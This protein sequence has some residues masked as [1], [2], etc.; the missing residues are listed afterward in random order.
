MFQ[1]IR[2]FAAEPER[3]FLFRIALPL[4]AVLALASWPSH[5]GAQEAAG[6]QDE[7]VADPAGR[8]DNLIVRDYP[9]AKTLRIEPTRSKLVRT[10]RPV[11]RLSI[12]DPN[13]MDVTQYSPEEFEFIGRKSGETTLTIWFGEEG[14][15]PTVVRY[16]VQVGPRTAETPHTLDSQPCTRPRSCRSNR[17]PAT[18]FAVDSTAPAPRPC[19]PRKAISASMFHAAPASAEPRTNTTTPMHRIGLRP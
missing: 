19:S 12:T 2:P 11:T 8:Q 1:T 14:Q 4:L 16:L 6:A 13:I 3:D 5:V 10:R 7:W 15:E 18:V 17:S 9:L